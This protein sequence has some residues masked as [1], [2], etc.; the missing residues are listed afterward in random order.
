MEYAV[1]SFLTLIKCCLSLAEPCTVDKEA[2]SQRNIAF[3]Y[4]HYDKLYSPHYDEIEFRCTEGRRVGTLHMRQR[5]VDG[6]M[7]LP[8]CQ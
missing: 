5:C 8:T 6:V 3:K 1:Q 4:T 7:H 2:M